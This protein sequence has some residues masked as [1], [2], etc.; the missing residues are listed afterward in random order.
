MHNKYKNIMKFAAECGKS[1]DIL[2]DADV[3]AKAIIAA[4]YDEELREEALRYAND[5]FDYAVL[6]DKKEMQKIEGDI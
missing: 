6:R 2:D 3:I 5:A 4:I 1:K